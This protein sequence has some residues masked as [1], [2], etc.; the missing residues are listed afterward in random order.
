[1]LSNLP[2][3]TL[4]TN[5]SA[6]LGSR[7]PADPAA[8]RPDPVE[9]QQR[10]FLLTRLYAGKRPYD[11]GDQD[12][13][14]FK[15]L[16]RIF[17]DLNPPGL[18]LDRM[19]KLAE[20]KNSNGLGFF[21]DNATGLKYYVKKAKSAEHAHNEVMFANVARLWGVAVPQVQLL[22]HKG[23][24]FIASSLIEGLELANEMFPNCA[25]EPEQLVRIARECPE[26]WDA[27]VALVA[28]NNRDAVG[29]G[30]D[31]LGFVRMPDGRL[32]PYFID[33]G[34]SGVYRATGGDKKFDPAAPEFHAMTEPTLESG[35]NGMIFGLAPR[36]VHLKALQRIYDVPDEALRDEIAKHVFDAR[37][38]S[39]VF[40]TLIARR[41]AIHA[42]I[43]AGRLNRLHNKFAG[44]VDYTITSAFDWD[45][46]DPEIRV[47]VKHS[48][49]RRF[50]NYLR[51]NVHLMA[52]SEGQMNMSADLDAK[53][54]L[55]VDVLV[56]LKRPDH[57]RAARP[58]EVR[59]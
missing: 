28:T 9:P 35:P 4:P 13:L 38:A 24:H 23:G 49:Q 6:A 39:Q 5:P 17:P 34:G 11:A 22:E 12:G 59:D 8:A 52:T 37:A 2:P 58:K 29:I 40:D 33:F 25:I 44:V 41:D 46:D 54:A 42:Q 32:K 55:A 43:G 7:P 18:T 1:M 10:P 20:P 48:L 19:T 14:P 30:C 51:D 15:P 53:I 45:D 56:R 3:P 31:N 16:A 21:R 36:A 50:P 26:V 57:D 27:F 47:Q